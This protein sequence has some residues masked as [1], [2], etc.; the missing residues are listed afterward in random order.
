[1]RAICLKCGSNK[2]QPCERCEACSFR[3]SENSDDLVKSVYLSLGRYDTEEER[4]RYRAELDTI[5]RQLGAGEE[6]KFDRAE[7][8]R[9]RRQKADVDSTGDWSLF[10]YLVRLFLPGIVIVLLLIGI[11]Y[12]L[13]KL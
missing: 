13:R 6:I 5:S 9:L 8:E 1:M 3:P 10:R 12:A 11:L 7:L 2:S 4:T